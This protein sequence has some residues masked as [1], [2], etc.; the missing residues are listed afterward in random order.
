MKQSNT[1]IGGLKKLIDYVILTIIPIIAAGIVVYFITKSMAILAL[2]LYQGLNMFVFFFSFLSIRV[3]E[4][5]TVIRFP[6]GTGK[7]ENFASFF[8][9][10]V[11]IPACAYIIAAGIGKLLVPNVNISFGITQLLLVFIISRAIFITWYARR[12]S[13]LT[14][15]PMA[16]AYYEN[17]RTGVF[18]FAGAFIALFAAGILVKAGHPKP[19]AYIDPALAIAAMSFMLYVSL[20]Q[21]VTNYRVLIDLPLS[22]EEQIRILNA[23]AREFESYLDIGNIYT[24]ASGKHRFIDIE[25]YFNSDAT[26]DSINQ[27]RTNLH[28]HLNANFSSLTFNLIPLCQP[29]LEKSIGEIVDLK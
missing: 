16:I 8:L 17:F 27:V 3:I 4:K 9:G 14:S 21:V 2:V 6:Y 20:R 13:R 7:L 23:L 25:L 1:E 28:A 10:A 12:I 29:K 18:F 22:E 11:S 26:L 19:A 15:S 5:S 24:R